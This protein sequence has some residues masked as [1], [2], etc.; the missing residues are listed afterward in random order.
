M[1]TKYKPEPSRPV[2]VAEKNSQPQHNNSGLA[3]IKIR[4]QTPNPD[5]QVADQGPLDPAEPADEPGREL[6]RNAVCK[7]EID[8]L[9]RKDTKELSPDRHGIVKSRA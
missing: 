9:L 3:K 5:G 1:I 7:E 6:P 2:T 8:V 4:E